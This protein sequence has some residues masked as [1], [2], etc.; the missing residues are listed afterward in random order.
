MAIESCGDLASRDGSIVRIAE[1]VLLILS[2]RQSYLHQN[3]PK[4]C[5]ATFNNQQES[6]WLG[7]RVAV[8]CSHLE[9]R[10]DALNLSPNIRT[11][12]P[13]RLTFQDCRMVHPQTARAEQFFEIAERE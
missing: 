11:A 2:L 4:G 6:E 7:R 1:C 8:S 10:V 12:H 9:Q 3:P 13:P 5:V